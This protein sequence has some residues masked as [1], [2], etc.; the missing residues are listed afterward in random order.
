MCRTLTIFA[1]VECCFTSTK[2]VGL[3]GTGA[4]DGY[5]D[6]HTAPGLWYWRWFLP[7]HTCSHPSACAP[8]RTHVCHEMG[9]VCLVC[10]EGIDHRQ[11]ATVNNL[12]CCFQQ[13]RPVRTKY[14]LNADA[15]IKVFSDENPAF[16]MCSFY[17][18]HSVIKVFPQL[19]TQRYQSVLS[20]EN[21][22]LSKCS[23]YWEPS[24]N[25]VYF[26]LKT[27]RYQSVLSTENTALSKCSFYWEPSVIRVFF[28]LRT[29]RYQSVLST[30]NTALS[31][32]SFC[33]EPSV[34][35]V[36]FLLRTQRYQNVPPVLQ[37]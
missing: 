15:A 3:L 21:T 12:T 10:V 19:S 35:S 31:K 17:W 32:C 37:E 27:Q 18:E 16:S 23:L 1:L 20:T 2:T 30:E 24:V 4:Q 6:F 5:L 28:L 29:Q 8:S 13:P 22:T 26:L 11:E 33:W 34:V 7:T 25:K 14:L 9:A 36:F